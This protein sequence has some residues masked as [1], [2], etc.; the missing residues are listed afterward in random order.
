MFFSKSRQLINGFTVESYILIVRYKTTHFIGISYHGFYRIIRLNIVHVLYSM[1]FSWFTYIL[2]AK[3]YLI[4]SILTPIAIDSYRNYSPTSSTKNVSFY[5]IFTLFL[6]SLL[7]MNI[8]E[9][10]IR[11]GFQ[12]QRV[13]IQILLVGLDFKALYG[14]PDRPNPSPRGISIRV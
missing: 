9:S 4:V 6:T 2:M 1:K 8:K 5:P 3:A 14:P 13:A 7:R 12:S 10:P 11:L